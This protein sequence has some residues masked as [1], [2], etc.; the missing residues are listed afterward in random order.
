MSKNSI[1]QLIVALITLGMFL[2]AWLVF[3]N[4]KATDW[5][6]LAIGILDLITFFMGLGKDR[7]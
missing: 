7:K 3:K 5:L 2:M 6:L 1:I 4:I